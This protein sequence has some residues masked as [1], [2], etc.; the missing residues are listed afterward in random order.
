M[1][2]A[3]PHRGSLERTLGVSGLSSLSYPYWPSTGKPKVPSQ[4]LPRHV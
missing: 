1:L 2:G 4:L 3:C